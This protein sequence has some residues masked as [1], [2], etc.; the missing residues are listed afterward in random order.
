MPGYEFT[1]SMTL[2][3][4]T[5]KE[6]LVSIPRGTIIEPESTHL[7]FQ[8]AVVAKDYL[9]TLAPGEK[10]SVLLE[11]ECWNRHLSPPKGV[12]GKVTPFKGSIA[13]TADIWK[14][15][16]AP[17]A[18]TTFHSPSLDGHVFSALAAFDPEHA[19]EFLTTALNNAESLG[20]D[21]AAARAQVRSSSSLTQAALAR[22]LRRIS[23]LPE[24]ASQISGRAIREHIIRSGGPSETNMDRMAGVATNLH[25]L[26]GHRLTS[27][28][29]E[30]AMDLTSLRQ[31]LRTALR[32]V[33]R[34]DLEIVVRRKFLDLVDALPLIDEESREHVRSAH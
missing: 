7:T 29:Y 22:E 23:K 31:E 13:K 8:S 25:A 1:V 15:S 9:F 24:L 5:S 16:S 21:V 12:P 19:R 18:D 4:A 11:V 14:T 17:S 30:L 28:L 3:N 32:E 10:R 2:E 26:N 33:E 27:K 34:K 6:Q 20:A